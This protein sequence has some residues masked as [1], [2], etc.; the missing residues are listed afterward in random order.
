MAVP[1]IWIFITIALLLQTPVMLALIGLA[2]IVQRTSQAAFL[3]TLDNREKQLAFVLQSHL[4]SMTDMSNKMTLIQQGNEATRKLVSD[5]A[6]DL[7]NDITKYIQ[8]LQ[9]PGPY[10]FD[11]AP[12]DGKQ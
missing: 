8:L 12:V 7:H 4:T 3:R 5:R 2:V 9:E 11:K 1:S 10:L 6:N